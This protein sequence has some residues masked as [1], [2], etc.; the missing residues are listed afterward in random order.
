MNRSPL[1]SCAACRTRSSRWD[2]LSRLGVRRMPRFIAFP[3]APTLGSIDSAG[4]CLPLF[5]DFP[6]TMAGSDFSWPCVIGFGS[7]AF[8]LRTAFSLA[9]SHEI[10]R[11][12][13]RKCR[14][15]ARV[16][17][18]AGPVG[19]WRWRTP[20][21]CLP[22]HRKRRHPGPVSL[23]G[24]IP[25][26][27]PPLPTLRPTPHGLTRMTQGRCGSL[28]LHRKGLAPSPSCRSPGAP[29]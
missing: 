17:D 13:C 3:L 12:P 22:L 20:P 28:Y 11:F 29:V 7:P 19:R 18:H 21:C 27:S 4:S 6:A 16:S 25:G 15:R 10:S 14:R 8:P 1:C 26:P 2:M 9:A 5:A 24:S 23:R